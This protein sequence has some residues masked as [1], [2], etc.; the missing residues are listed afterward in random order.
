MK[1][2]PRRKFGLTGLPLFRFRD[3]RTPPRDICKTSQAASLT[4]SRSESLLFNGVHLA[5]TNEHCGRLLHR[6]SDLQPGLEGP[7]LEG[8]DDFQEAHSKNS[9]ILAIKERVVLPP[10]THPAK[11]S[12]VGA[13]PKLAQRCSTAQGAPPQSARFPCQ[14]VM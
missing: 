5:H 7:G 3:Q 12:G 4:E 1:W 10:A 13:N 14:V 11:V 2:Y 8:K 6:R 9:F